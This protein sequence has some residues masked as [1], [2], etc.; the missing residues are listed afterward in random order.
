[1]TEAQ[2]GA[3]PDV[4]DAEDSP[5]TLY[6]LAMR[7]M[8]G[9]GFSE[10]DFYGHGNSE[11]EYKVRFYNPESHERLSANDMIVTYVQ[12]LLK[13][14]V[15]PVTVIDFGAG[16]GLT[17]CNA[18]LKLKDEIKTGKAQLVATNL[19]AK[20]TLEDIEKL[21]ADRRL[22]LK[23]LEDALRENLVEFLKADI[24]ELEDKLDGRK[25]DLMF[26]VN[27]FGFTDHFNDRLLATTAEILNTQSGTLVTGHRKM[28]GT[29][30][31]LDP[32]KVLNAGLDNIK[33]HGFKQRP[34]SPLKQESRLTFTLFQ[35]SQ[36]PQLEIA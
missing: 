16:E 14:G 24:D 12:T 22:H 27:M 29:L 33:A 19:V 23:P 31:Y 13:K 6:T 2:E 28:G 10:L 21:R 4:L 35:A 15:S 18:S 7:D 3:I 25:V 34:N 5:I 9:K 36:A 32:W 20:P 11:G 17:L 8:H 1:M 26:M 30:P